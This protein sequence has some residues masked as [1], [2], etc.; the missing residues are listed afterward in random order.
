[1]K[2]LNCPTIA[3]ILIISFIILSC[4]VI[5][6]QKLPDTAITKISRVELGNYYMKK[7]RNQKLLGYALLAGG[8]ASFAASIGLAYDESN[9]AEPLLILST[10]SLAASNPALCSGSKS[11]GKAEM[12]LR[13]PAPGESPE[14][15]TALARRYQKNAT[16][17]SIAAWTLFVG[18][19]TG[20]FISADDGSETGA[21]LSA[22]SM[23]ASLPVWMNSAKNKGRVSI[24]L[25]REYVPVSYK[26]NPSMPSIGISIP[27]SR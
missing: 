22:V 12:L 26:S 27:I 11:K 6:A 20:L 10:I 24:L 16:I 2:K 5:Q 21:V 3:S 8:F 4:P 7:S 9:A 15:V 1:M 13:N 14:D 19:I 18:G 25:Q 17:S 23:F